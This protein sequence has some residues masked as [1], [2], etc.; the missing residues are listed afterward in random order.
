MDLVLAQLFFVNAV[1]LARMGASASAVAGVVTVWGVVYFIARPVVGKF[2]TVANSTRLI[3]VSC[4]LLAG[5]CVLYLVFTSRDRGQSSD[6]CVG[7][8]VIF[9]T[10]RRRRVPCAEEG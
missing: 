7:G 2:L 5:Q 10:R 1:R 6:S 3:L 9:S 8:V 4:L